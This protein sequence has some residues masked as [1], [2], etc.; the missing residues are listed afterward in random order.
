MNLNNFIALTKNV[1]KVELFNASTDRKSF[2]LN[3][4]TNN[5]N[6]INNKKENQI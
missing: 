4:N 5:I 2:K 1:K 6:N 3:N